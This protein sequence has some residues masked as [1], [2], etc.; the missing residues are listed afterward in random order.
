MTTYRERSIHAPVVH[1]LSRKMV[2]I[3]GPRQVGKTTFAKHIC[4]ETGGESEKHYLNWDIA[5]HRSRIIAEEFPTEADF[6]ILDEIHKYS[7]WRQVVKGL[8]DEKP[9]ARKILVT[10]S[11]RLDYY[12]HGGDSLQGRYRFYRL[13]PFICSELGEPKKSTIDQLL[14]LGP[15]PEPFLSG[16]ERDARVWSRDYR[17]RV[18]EEDLRGLE[19]V[20]DTALLE[21]L[22]MLLPERVGSPLS[23]NGLKEDLQVA[24]QTVARWITILESLYMIYRIYPFTG[25]LTRSIKKEAKHYHFDWT[26]IDEPGARFENLVANHLL[27]WCWRQ[28]D[29]EGRDVELRYFRDMDRREV[30]F[31]VTEKNRP[32]HLIEVKLRRQDPS[33]SLRYLADRFPKASACQ[34]AFDDDDDRITKEGIRLCGWKSLWEWGSMVS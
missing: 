32:L 15:F 31:V 17:T 34:I 9:G 10:G 12:R 6:I 27:A 13:L 30:D 28:Q 19:Q 22:A 21:K 16:S 11:A 3:G 7:R 23:L 8:F 14:K 18:V 2:F 33:V 5:A 26:P 1:D 29:A 25:S 20:T 24:H 4:R